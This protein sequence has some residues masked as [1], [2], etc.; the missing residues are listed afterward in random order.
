VTNALTIDVEEYFHPAEVQ[1][2][3]SAKEWDRLP[4]RV[5]AETDRVLELL[6]RHHVTATFF[7]L[8]WVA[9]KHPE[10]VR[11][12]AAAGHEIGCH[13]YA[14]E[15]VYRLSPAAFRRDL[16]RA[17]GAIEAACGIRPRSYRAPS[18]SI[19]RASWWALEV[20]VECGFQY[21]C[22]IV[23]ITHDRYGIPGFGRHAGRVATPAGPILEIPAATTVSPGGAILPVGGG[24]YLRLLP[25]RYTA[26]GIRRLNEREA[27]PACIYFHPWE[28]DAEQPHLAG[29]WVSRLRTYTG[30]GSME[31]KLDR[32]LDDFDFSTLA[33]VY[34]TAK[35]AP[36]ACDG[37][38]LAR[39]GAA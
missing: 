18:F 14:H 1:R 10:V 39:H 20:L 4:S 30:L 17:V 38:R 7:V 23:P 11:R 12:I 16:E 28:L 33:A 37:P 2:C 26:A 8:G 19:T 32:L 35:A 5:D 21:D 31:K 34:P 3:G 29:G 6:N 25:Y 24:G 27:E 13:S 36:G 22:S 15:I 9:E